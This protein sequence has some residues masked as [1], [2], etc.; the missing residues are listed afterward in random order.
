MF[1]SFVLLK[2]GVLLGIPAS[3]SL[4]MNFDCLGRRAATRY[5]QYLQILVKLLT[6]RNVAA[7]IRYVLT[8]ELTADSAAVRSIGPWQ[9]E[10]VCCSE[11]TLVFVIRG[12]LPRQLAVSARPA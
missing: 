9:S 5:L 1:S 4:R 7:S 12:E 8:A 11:A 6:S 10:E 2:V 3:C